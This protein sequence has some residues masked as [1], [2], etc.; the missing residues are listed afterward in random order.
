[1]SVRRGCSRDPPARIAL[2]GI[3]L[4]RGRISRR[5][6]DQRELK[7]RQQAERRSAASESH[8]RTILDN[9][10]DAV[11]VLTPRDGYLDVNP[12]GSDLT[13]YTRAELLRLTTEDTYVLKS[14]GGGAN[15]RSDH[16]A[17]LDVRPRLLRKTVGCPRRVTAVLLPDGRIL[18]TLHDLSEER[19]AENKIR[20][21]EQRFRELAE[22]VREFFIMDQYRV[23]PNT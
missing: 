18:T 17:H 9:V 12:P 7:Q 11:F 3:L 19:K 14:D 4:T 10:A 2:G 5:R 20:E 16:G 8:Y 22:N 6:P 23:G 13:G 21:S 1:M 15:R